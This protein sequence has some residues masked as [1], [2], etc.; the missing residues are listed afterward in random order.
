M[1]RVAIIIVTHN[2]G[3]EIGRCLDALAATHSTRET[4]TIVVDNA[5][6][7]QTVAEVAARG[8]RFIANANNAGFAAAVNQGIRAGDAPLILVLNPDA[9]LVTACDALAALFTDPRTGAAGGMLIDVLGRPQTG[10]M[11]RNLP[12]PAALIFEVLGINRLWPSNPVNWQYRC[13][14]MDPMTP[15]PVEQ[16]A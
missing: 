13:L 11:A 6:R 12:T 15:G 3:T 4:E 14:G 16:P 1:S 8:V 9:H 2:S 5:S 7:D 10:F